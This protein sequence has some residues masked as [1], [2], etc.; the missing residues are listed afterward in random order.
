MVTSP[1]STPVLTYASVHYSDE[2]YEK[3]NGWM[4]ILYPVLSLHL[5]KNE[6][7]NLFS[8]I[9]RRYVPK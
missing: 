8:S 7:Y 4:E 9:L 1:V 6:S 3:D 2:M 5:S